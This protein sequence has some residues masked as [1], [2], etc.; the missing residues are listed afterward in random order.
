M[1]YSLRSSST[2]SLTLQ[3]LTAAIDRQK[4]ELLDV[5]QNQKKELLDELA[6]QKEDI[7]N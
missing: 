5:F 4:K 1:A 6:K 7:L 2:M 3:N